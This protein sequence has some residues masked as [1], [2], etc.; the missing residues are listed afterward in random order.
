[1]HA[2]CDIVTPFIIDSLDSRGRIARLDD[3]IN[4]ILTPHDYPEPVAHLVAQV[5]TLTAMLG[6]ALKIDGRFSIQIRSDGPISLIVCDFKSPNQLRSSATFNKDKIPESNKLSNLL[7]KGVLTL[8]A[9]QNAKVPLYQ[10]IVELEGDNLSDIAEK[11]YTQS[12]QI[13]TQIK[14]TSG[15][16]ID[17]KTGEKKWR[18][19]GFLL[20]YLP[21]SSENRKTQATI[22]NWNEAKILSETLSDS[23]LLD[24]ENLSTNQ[25]LF[26]LYNQYE[27]RV[28]DPIKM[29]N[30]CNC[31]HERVTE[32]FSKLSNEELEQYTEDGKINIECQFC[33]SKYEFIPKGKE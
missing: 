31:N 8:I 24:F 4:N 32:L 5:T 19:G 25:L 15:L 27:V 12:E 7:G 29:E 14:L 16:A 9:D 23:E 2:E 22:E 20:Q 10:A 11:Y 30:K 3:A 28:F 1:M 33:R 18:S 13:P 6:S 17:S 26:R 21:Y